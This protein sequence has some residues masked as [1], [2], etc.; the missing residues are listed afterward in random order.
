MDYLTSASCSKHE[1]NVNRSI[2]V[3]NNLP[4]SLE[5][6]QHRQ[7]DELIQHH[8]VSERG[9][10]L[11]IHGIKTKIYIFPKNTCSNPLTG[12][13]FYITKQHPSSIPVTSPWHQQTLAPADQYHQ[14][15]GQALLIFL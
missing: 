14:R 7:A 6:A 15:L 8:K 10:N 13:P 1:H 9:E 2:K 11:R 3:A 5:I 12:E 4:L